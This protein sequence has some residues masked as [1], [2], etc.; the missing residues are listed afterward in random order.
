MISKTDNVHR[1][2]FFLDGVFKEDLDAN[3]KTN[4]LKFIVSNIPSDTQTIMSIADHKEEDSKI[5]EYS[6]E[7]FGEVTNLICIG[8]GIEQKA[9]L[10][11]YDGSHRDIVDDSYGIIDTF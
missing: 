10:T 1:L 3:S 2:P 9:L 4:I 5:E 11:S 6:N 7:I 8:N